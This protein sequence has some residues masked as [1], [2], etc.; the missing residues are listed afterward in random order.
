MWFAVASGGAGPE[1]VC[2]REFWQ[3][4][5]WLLS[6]MRGWG[7]SA[8]GGGGTILSTTPSLEGKKTVKYLGLVSG[9]AIV[10]IDI[11]QET[12]GAGIAMLMGRGTVVVVEPE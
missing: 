2:H 5:W 9:G 6:R 11:G 12:T 8:R 1:A 4:V 3:K 10:G 7:R